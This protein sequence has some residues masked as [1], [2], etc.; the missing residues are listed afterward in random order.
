MQQ[1]GGPGTLSQPQQRQRE[2]GEALR[3]EADRLLARLD[4]AEGAAAKLGIERRA[5]DEAEGSVR[6]VESAA[7]EA[8]RKGEALRAQ[9]ALLVAKLEDLSAGE[10][11]R[12]GAAARKEME[13]R[14][15][16]LRHIRELEEQLVAATEELQASKV[17]REDAE[18]ALRGTLTGSV[19]AETELGEFQ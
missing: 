16:S 11:A 7:A 3:A 2:G 5:R 4:M 15:A 19:R 12:A 17:A 14:A 8:A 18:W 10:R 9:V 13:M 1:R 6:D